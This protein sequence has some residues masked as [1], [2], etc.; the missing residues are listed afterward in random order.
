MVNISSFL[1][2]TTHDGIDVCLMSSALSNPNTKQ[3]LKTISIK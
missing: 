3:L 2:E 1:S